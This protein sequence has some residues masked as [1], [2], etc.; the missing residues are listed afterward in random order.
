MSTAILVVDAT[1]R[2]HA[3]CDLFAR[4]HPGATVFYAG[5]N[6]IERDRIVPVEAISLTDPW[7]ALGFLLENSVEFTFVSNIDALSIG[8]VDVLRAHGHRVIGPTAA[9]AQ[10]EAS[11]ERGKRFCTDHGIPTAPYR[12]FIDPRAAKAYLRSLPYACVVKTDGLCKD[13]DGAV[14]CDTN[15]QAE[16]AVDGFAA[17]FGPAF[18]VVIEQRLYGTE[19]SVFALLDGNGGYLPFPTALDFKRACDDDR[20]TNCDGM[21]SIAPHPA[22]TPALRDEIRAVLLE[23]LVRGLRRDRLDYSGFVYVG[24]MMTAQGLRVIEINARFGDSEAEAV[25][26]GVRSDFVRLCRVVLAGSLGGETLETDGCVRCSVALTQG[27]LAPSDPAAQP[28]WPFGAFATG[29]RI[30]GLGAPDT[31]DATVF[32]ANVRRAAGVPVTCGGRVLHVVGRGTSL[33]Q[34]RDNAYGRIGRIGFDG[35]RYRSDIGAGTLA[36]SAR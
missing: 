19:I 18:R 4:T 6:A 28:G 17:Q 25:L 21:G 30:D 1:G 2:G 23:P 34:A 10:L 12:A 3:I 32:Y 9:A 26:P 31:A 35:M 14:V 24:A 33:E 7:T 11:K 15:A 36:S 22:E 16:A 5:S 20:G 27:S 29:Q 8:Y 13:G